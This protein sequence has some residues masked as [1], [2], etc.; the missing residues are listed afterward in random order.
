MLWDWQNG[1]LFRSIETNGGLIVVLRFLNEQWLLSVHN[2]RHWEV[3]DWQNGNL[4]R[5]L[6]GIPTNKFGLFY[7]SSSR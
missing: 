5:T 3:W 4:V 7:Q 1:K 2:D 6:T